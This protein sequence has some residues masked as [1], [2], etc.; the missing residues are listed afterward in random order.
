MQQLKQLL[1]RV[2]L[3][4]KSSLVL[5]LFATCQRDILNLLA[6]NTQAS[7]KMRRQIMTG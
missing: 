4:D 3:D 5:H 2:R 7:V 6:P 1:L